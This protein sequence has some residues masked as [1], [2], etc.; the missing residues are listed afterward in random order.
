M[1]LANVLTRAAAEGR[2]ILAEWEHHMRLLAE[3]E[4]KG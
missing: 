2:A 3:R 1:E 4:A